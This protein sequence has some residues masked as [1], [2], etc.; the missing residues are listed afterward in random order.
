M[1]NLSKNW[2]DYECI[3]TG[4][5]EKIERWGNI[6][7][8]R[9]DPQ[10]I[11]N[12]DKKEKLYNK[13]MDKQLALKIIQICEENSIYYSIMANGSIITKNLKYNV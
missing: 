6:I 2:I 11:W 12:K 8:N 3:A 9:P 7:L 4:E 13:F 5:G 10:I 1:I